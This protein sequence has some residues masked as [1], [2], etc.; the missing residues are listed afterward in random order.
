MSELYKV[1]EVSTFKRY[2]IRSNL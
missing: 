1:H 2:V